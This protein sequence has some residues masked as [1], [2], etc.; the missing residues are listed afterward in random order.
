MCSTWKKD[1]KIEEIID[2]SSKL[3]LNG[4]EIW[5]GHIDDYLKRNKCGIEQLKNLL[6][7]RQ[8]ECVAIAPY[9]NF[10]SEDLS[11]KSISDAKKSVN[12]AK[13]LGCQIIRT[14]LGNKASKDMNND[15]WKRCVLS[16]KI[17]TDYVKNENIYFAMETHN[18]HPTD[19]A[20]AVL[21]II[22]QVNSANLKVLFDGFN[23][24]IDGVNM[25]KAYD[26]LKTYVVHY[27]MKNY[28]WKDRVSMPLNKGDVDF[29][30]LFSQIK[31]AGYKGFIS[32]EYF[33]DNPDEL[34]KE[35]I[36]WIE[37]IK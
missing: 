27:H 29:T 36:Q 8:L 20:E 31:K 5:D 37:S 26:N 12:Y 6:K 16:L 7:S 13:E 19:T 34:I 22:N 1:K 23:Y 10:I 21:E 35:S 14:F 4:I 33:C 25:L 15:E 24:L 2:Y 30:E 32:F 3:G 28:L 17:I 11:E 18:D 9:F